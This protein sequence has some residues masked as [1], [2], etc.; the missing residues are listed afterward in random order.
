MHLNRKTILNIFLCIFTTI[1]YTSLVG[2]FLYLFKAQGFS[3]ILLCWTSLVSLLFFATQ[4]LVM[5][6]LFQHLLKK[7]F[8]VKNILYVILKIFLILT[9]TFGI[10]ALLIQLSVSQ[11]SLAEAWLESTRKG[12]PFGFFSFFA[13]EIY[14]IL[15]IPS[16]YFASIKKY[17]TSILMLISINLLCYAIIFE[18]QWMFGLA[19]F[20]SIAP[21]FAKGNWKKLFLPLICSCLVSLFCTYSCVNKN[22]TSSIVNVDLTKL[23]TK[24]SPDFPLMSHIP[25]YGF[26]IGISKP[27]HIVVMSPRILYSVQGRINSVYYFEENRYK[28]WDGSNWNKLHRPEYENNTIINFVEENNQLEQEDNQLV[29]LT[30]KEDFYTTIPLLEN[31]NRID[32]ST[33][34]KEAQFTILDANCISVIPSLI[35]GTEITLYN[36]KNLFDSAYFETSDSVISTKIREFAKKLCL[37]IE[38]ELIEQNGKFILNNNQ[39][40]QYIQKVL[41]YF[42][43]DFVYSLESPPAPEG[44]DPY[45]YFLFESKKGFCTWFSGAFCLLMQCTNIPCRIVEGFRTKIDEKGLG[46][47]AGYNGHAW[48]EV[49]INGKWQVVEATIVYSTDNPYLY[50]DKK[51]NQTKKML[52]EVFNDEDGELSPRYKKFSIRVLIVPLLVILCI[53]VCVLIIWIIIQ[54]KSIVQKGRFYVRH[55][56]KKGIPSPKNIGWLLWKEQIQTFSYSNSKIEKKRAEKALKIADELMKLTYEE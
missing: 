2:L 37:Q 8:S 31:T 41:D 27:R 24:I 30:L 50:V 13:A 25:G 11:R 17:I 44:T 29:K 51:D 35:K 34:Y 38:P 54:Y 9:I 42:K 22:I 19:L 10:L 40:K 46:V 23:M 33:E 5:L 18:N 4:N 21:F 15:L 39:Q 45:E 7:K 43:T 52:Q 53:L 1:V 32:I 55:Y 47:I 26:T 20:L 48:N 28:S 6:N 12:S 36:D 49:F 56:S 14:A 3:V 16:V